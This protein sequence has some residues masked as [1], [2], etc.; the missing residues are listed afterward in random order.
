M[1]NFANKIQEYIF[2]GK[3]QMMRIKTHPRRFWR[4]KSVIKGT[5][6]Y[7][8]VEYEWNDE[9]LDDKWRI[10]WRSDTVILK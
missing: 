8:D 6:L 7:R 2:A 5:T 9:E 10:C 4:Q 3:N 1:K